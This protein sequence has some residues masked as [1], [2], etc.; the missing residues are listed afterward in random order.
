MHAYPRKALARRLVLWRMLELGPRFRLCDAEA[1]RFYRSQGGQPVSVQQ[2][3]KALESLR[4]RTPAM[5]WKSAR[6]EY[7]VDD[8]A[9]QLWAQ[10]RLAAG[11]WPPEPPA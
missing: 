1:L 9:L 5:V 10:A 4:Q 6:G 2:V 3:Q 8:A 11:T 7:A